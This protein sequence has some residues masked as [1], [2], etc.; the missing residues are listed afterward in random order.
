MDLKD[1]YQDIIL[2]HG[3][4]PRHFG[5]LEGATHEGHGHN[6]LCGDTVT[7]RLKLDGERIEDVRFEGRGCAISIASAS[8]MSEVLT[9]KSVV[10]AKALFGD[11]QKRATGQPS[12]APSGLEDEVERLEPLTG[13]S[14]YPMRVKCAV[15]P[16][17]TVNAALDKPK[18]DAS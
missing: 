7:V 8:L 15:L 12:E 17:H 6:P 2:D 1:L 11:F 3:R 10:E 18:D 16:W 14:Q 5:A 13:V 9:G 4:H